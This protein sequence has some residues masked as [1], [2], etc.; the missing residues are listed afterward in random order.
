MKNQSGFSLVELLVVVIIIAII[1][2]IAI[3]N[4]LASRKAAND[5]NAVAGMRTL[6]SAE[7]TYF[8]TSGNNQNYGDLTALKGDKLIDDNLGGGKTSGHT[9]AL[10][11]V[12]GKWCA[13]ATPG[14]TAIKYYAINEVNVI[15]YGTAATD[16][17]CDTATGV[18][19]F[20]ATAKVLGQ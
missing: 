14:S 16:S 10:G 15:Y 20:T 11:A 7:V 18:A 17:T 6:G 8:A 1:A 19:A 4:L 13:L 5:A 3:P 12:G 9:V 2:A